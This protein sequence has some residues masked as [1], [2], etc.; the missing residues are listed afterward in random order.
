MV[1]IAYIVQSRAAAALPTVQN[2]WDFVDSHI[3]GQMA[4]L[5]MAPSLQQTP[6][7]QSRSS[8][9]TVGPSGRLAE[10]DLQHGAAAQWRSRPQVA[11][12][13]H[14]GNSAAV[15]DQG[16][17]G[18]LQSERL[19]SGSPGSIAV[20]AK[21]VRLAVMPPASPNNRWLRLVA[22]ALLG[23]YGAGSK[24]APLDASDRQQAPDTT[25]PLPAAPGSAHITPVRSVRR[26]LGQSLRNV[27]SE[28][29]SRLHKQVVPLEQTALELDKQA[30]L[31]ALQSGSAGAS[32]EHEEVGLSLPPSGRDSGALGEHGAHAHAELADAVPHV[33]PQG[34]RPKHRT[35]RLHQ[36]P[37]PDVPEQVAH[38]GIRNCWV[39][40]VLAAARV[41][42][43]T[44]CPG[45]GPTQGL[46]QGAPCLR[47]V[48]RLRGALH[49]GAP[50]LAGGWRLPAAAAARR[51]PVRRCWAHTVTG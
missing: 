11:E 2:F 21:R 30:R 35:P 15:S 32:R 45:Q 4:A 14:V 6:T 22:P 34:P 36:A 33:P 46:P 5:S 49:T 12:F 7:L 10:S 39:Q 3:E 18:A 38:P 37:E 19:Q 51:D 27:L 8:A 31:I 16:A 28:A 44:T 42:E 1:H 47:L 24:V 25:M 29:T 9:P 41:N 26:R 50:L 23:S 43:Q 17:L 20:D 40:L 48:S 13:V